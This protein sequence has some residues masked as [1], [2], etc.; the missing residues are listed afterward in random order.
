MGK[1]SKRHGRKHGKKS[2]Q[3]KK[4]PAPAK[5]KTPVERPAG[6][7]ANLGMDKRASK[8]E[9][10]LA[11]SQES[12]PAKARRTSAT[13]A[14]LAQNLERSMKK[15]NVKHLLETRPERGDSEELLGIKAN[16]ANSIQGVAKKLEKKMTADSIHHKL[17]MRPD[18]SYLIRQGILLKAMLHLLPL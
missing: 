14:G 4:A 8:L 11:K 10:Q 6:A 7:T 12:M 1:K 18:P 15:N 2:P 9:A 3:K 5:P 17:E 13:I 16:L